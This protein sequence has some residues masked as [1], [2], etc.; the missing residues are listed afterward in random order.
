[1]T[2]RTLGIILTTA[3]R[4]LVAAAVVAVIIYWIGRI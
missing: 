3:Q 4:A 2:R 1:M